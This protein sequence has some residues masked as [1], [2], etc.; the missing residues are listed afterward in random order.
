MGH[1]CWQQLHLTSKNKCWEN[2]CSL[3]SNPCI[4]NWP[5]KLLVCYWRLT[6]Q[7]WCICWNTKNHSRAKWKKPW[8]CSKPTKQ[9]KRINK[10]IYTIS[11][12]FLQALETRRNNIKKKLNKNYKK[13]KNCLKQNKNYKKNIHTIYLFLLKTTLIKKNVTLQLYTQHTR[14]LVK[15][16]LLYLNSFELAFF[17]S[18]YLIYL[19]NNIIST[20]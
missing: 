17:T 5:A 20:P 18:L 12:R 14:L 15:K 4:K 19:L 16:R 2:V 3:L 11:F 13:S 10:K 9:I 1:P 6:T 7:N 8:L